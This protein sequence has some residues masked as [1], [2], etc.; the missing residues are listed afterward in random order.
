MKESREGATEVQLCSSRFK[1]KDETGKE[2]E[3]D[4][5]PAQESG[6]IKT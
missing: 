4:S 2:T 3:T 6:D 1:D 5:E